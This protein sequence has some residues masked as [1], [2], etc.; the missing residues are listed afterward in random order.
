MPPPTL[1]R[2]N[3]IR[4]TDDVTDQ[5][6]SSAITGALAAITQEELQVFFLSRLRQIIWGENAPEHWYD[7]LFAQGIV[8]LKDLAGSLAPFV[9]VG[10]QLVGPQ[11]GV[12]RVFRT[13]PDHFVHDP[14]GTGHT[15]EL[16]HN[17][18][19]LTQTAVQDPGIGDYWVEESG[20]VGTG[21]DTLNLLTFAP[22]VK[23]SLVASYQRV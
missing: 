11:N 5:Q 3:R 16:W 18:R 17:G 4:R 23:S 10:V 21:F 19:R 9:R 14:A 6:G 12:N 13:T 15:I 22:V 7:D 2:Y 20:G 1:Q 8:S